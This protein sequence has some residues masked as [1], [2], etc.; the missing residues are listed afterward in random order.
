MATIDNLCNILHEF[1]KDESDAYGSATLLPDAT[2]VTSESVGSDITG[3]VGVTCTFAL[4]S[5]SNTS[6]Q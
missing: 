3:L 4:Q 5:T 6:T 1:G 2:V